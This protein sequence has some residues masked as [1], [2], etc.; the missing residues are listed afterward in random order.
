VAI[1]V[2]YATGAFSRKK[3]TGKDKNIT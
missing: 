2:I 3:S 1:W